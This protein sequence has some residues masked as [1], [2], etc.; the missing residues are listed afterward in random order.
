MKAR[1]DNV[2]RS[3]EFKRQ[4]TQE[5]LTEKSLHALSKRHNSR[6]LGFKSMKRAP[7][8]K[9]LERMPA[10]KSAAVHGHPHLGVHGD[11]TVRE[12]PELT[13]LASSPEKIHSL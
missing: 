7:W 5:F 8:T 4:V 3:I 11:V 2:P 9:R 12:A 1:P 10:L 6:Q 13:F